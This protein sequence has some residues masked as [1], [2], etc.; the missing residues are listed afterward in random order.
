MTP[1]KHSTASTTSLQQEGSSSLEGVM[2]TA[3]TGLPAG[4]TLSAPPPQQAE[5]ADPAATAATTIPVATTRPAATVPIKQEGLSA[6]CGVR[7]DEVHG[8]ALKNITKVVGQWPQTQ[9]KHE[10]SVLKI[11]SHPMVKRWHA[12]SRS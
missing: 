5:T 8:S 6:F 1:S 2:R 3:N 4:V 7:Y 12:S 11:Q 9:K 10:L